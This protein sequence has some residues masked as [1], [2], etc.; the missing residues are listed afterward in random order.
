[1]LPLSFLN[2]ILACRCEWVKWLTFYVKPHRYLV[3]LYFAFGHDEGYD[4]P[5]SA[6]G[7]VQGVLVGVVIY[8][9]FVCSNPAS[10]N[11]SDLHVMGFC[12]HDAQVQLLLPKTEKNY[13]WKSQHTVPIK[14]HEL[15]KTKNQPVI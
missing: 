10:E 14:K 15:F 5:V 6:Q 3:I 13:V 12:Y 9:S 1:M 4:E 11:V 8:Q 2:I 7:Q